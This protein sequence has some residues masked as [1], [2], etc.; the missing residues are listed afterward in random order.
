MMIE[1][2]ALQA[3][4]D[5]LT[6][7]V[8]VLEAVGSGGGANDLTPRVAALEAELAAVHAAMAPKAA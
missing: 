5:A 6:A 3:K 7:R 8:S 1:I 4:L 2:Q